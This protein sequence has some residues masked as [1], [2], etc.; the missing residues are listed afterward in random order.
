MKTSGNSIESDVKLIAVVGGVLFATLIGALIVVQQSLGS[1]Q[2]QLAETVVPIQQQLGK[3]AGAEGSMFLRQSEI[4]A[5]NDAALKALGDRNNH[6]F[7]VRNGAIGF[8]ELVNTTGLNTEQGFPIQA[9]NSL[10]NEIEVFLRADDE[11]FDA[12]SSFQ[13][14]KK[15][16]ATSIESIEKDLR[17]LIE[18]SDG[19]AGVLRLAHVSQLRKLSQKLNTESIR[20]DLLRPVIMGNSR[21]QL[22]TIFQ[23]DTAVLRLGVLAGKVGLATSEDSLNSLAANELIQNREQI[24]HALTQLE[25]QVSDEELA[26][27]VR[28]LRTK[29][30][31]LAK[32]VGDETYPESL[33]SL[34]RRMLQEEQRVHLSQL[35]TAD[36]S[37]QLESN[38]ADLQRYL[39]EVANRAQDSAANTIQRSRQVTLTISVITLGL[40]V[41]AAFRIHSSVL[42]LRSQNRQ[43]SE[44]SDEL[45]KTNL[46]LEKMVAER[47]ASLQLVLDSTGDGLLS[48]DLNG[49]LLPERSRAVTV[50]FGES[51]PVATLWDYLASDTLTKDSLEMAIEQLAADVF[52]FEVAADQAP[53]T[54]ERDG[55]TFALEYRE[56]REQNRLARI[57]VLVRDVTAEL[58]VKRAEREMRELHTLV[59]NLLKDRQ[60]FDQ[61]L[62][63]CA[64]LVSEIAQTVSH[65]VAKRSLHTLKGNCAIVGFQSVADYVH[66]LEGMLA[67]ES[68]QPTKSEIVDLDRYW[69][70][71]LTKIRNYLHTGRESQI[72]IATWE[73]AA[74]KELLR[75]RASYKEIED[76]VNSWN[77][78]PTVTQLSRL[79]DQ[80]R[81]VAKRLGKQIEV[82]IQDNRLR[83][84]EEGLRRFWS[85]LIHA[86]RNA[87]DHGI[88][89]PEQRLEKGKP[90]IA[91]LELTTRQFNGHFEIEISDDGAGID[92]ER[93]R[94]IARERGLPHATE[95]ELIEALFCDGVSTREVATDISGRGVG[96][97][98]VRSECENVGGTVSVESRPEIGTRF[99]FRFPLNELSLV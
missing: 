56:I 64:S 81:Q 15:Q 50:W 89:P 95:S 28:S 90:A 3:I 73:Y 60:G 65:A 10:E 96:L 80:S 27:R 72:E 23:L 88:E 78:E 98:A 45:T 2:S 6:E 62:E 79:A 8:R 7:A 99:V 12:A 25:K 97:S 84:P 71:S 37:E 31:D 41:I 17:G 53:K 44:L 52:P 43:L 75:N 1:S 14:L 22:D 9:A 92:W 93:V 38:T 33:A 77:N 63:E 20:S 21:L 30:I 48:V 68:R 29:A 34:H 85:S 26:E 58:E 39:Q 46:S 40:A 70:N 32:R 13:S 87:V 74:I 42:A 91:K 57:L 49:V 19:L 11:L 36:V 59:G 82:S 18:A 67:D 24:M 47:T 61:T 5:A 86:I 4:V 16:I 76:V 66:E 69:Q 35:A 94:K 51:Q 54:I 55:K 83:I